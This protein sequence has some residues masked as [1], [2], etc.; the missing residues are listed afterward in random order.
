MPN[1]QDLDDDEVS[2]ITIDSLMSIEIRGWARRNLSL[3][4]SLAEITK[5]GT[6]GNLGN[7][8]IEH[9]RVKYCPQAV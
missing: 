7:V 3:E 9:L 2:K 5:A 4:I 1:T 8:V 6:V